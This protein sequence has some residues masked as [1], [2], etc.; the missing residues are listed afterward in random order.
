[1]TIPQWLDWAQRLQSIAQTGLC[2]NPPP[3][4]KQRYDM[5]LDIA[6]EM[7]AAGSQDGLTVETLNTLFAAQAGHATPKVDTRGVVFRDDHILLVQEKMDNDRWT[8]PGGWADVGESASESAVREVWEESGYRVRALKLL[9]AFDR[10]KHP[11]PPFAF[12]AY[13]LFFRCELT[14]D[15]RCVDP[16]NIEINGVDWFREDAL[17]ELSIARITPGQIARFFEHYR[18]PDLPTDFD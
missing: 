14:D 9:A 18:H 7:M 10:N 3:F 5:I 4:D 8:L 6:A 15:E 1:M 12:H 11:H 16:D 17:P 13:K 2:Y